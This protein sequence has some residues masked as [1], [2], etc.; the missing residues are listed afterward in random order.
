MNDITTSVVAQVVA[1]SSLPTPDL[2]A[3][4]D[5][6]YET[7]PDTLSRDQ[8]ES[9][10]A[11]S[12]QEKA[13]REW[14]TT[15]CVTQSN[16]ELNNLLCGFLFDADGDPMFPT[17]A[18]GN[19]K[20]RRYYI[21]K[22]NKMLD[23]E[24]TPHQRVSVSACAIEATAIKMIKRR[25]TKL[26]AAFLAVGKFIEMHAIE[27][28]HDEIALAYSLGRLSTA[29]HQLSPPERIRIVK[30]MI[31]RVDLVTFS[32][33]IVKWRALDYQ[34]LVNQCAALGNAAQLCDMQPSEC[35]DSLLSFVPL[36]LRLRARR[37][38]TCP[39]KSE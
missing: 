34:E 2:W 28:D 37:K 11:K 15:S 5:R 30:L 32:E 26:S 22:S 9:Q 13:L 23:A 35:A 39:E 4:W 1:L 7:R 6:Y 27:M 3:L 31:E 12:L 8:I 10:V 14:Q 24:G 18:W 29:W 21:S 19:G 25:L 17:I 20:F 36:P 33:L 16:I 38:V